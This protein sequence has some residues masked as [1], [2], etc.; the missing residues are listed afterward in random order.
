MIQ[1]DI[2]I[3][4]AGPS[5]VITSLLLAQKGIPSVLVDKC[6]FPRHKACADAIPS[7]VIRQLNEIIPGFMA[8]L[9]LEKKSLEIKGTL[10]YSPAGD[11]VKVDFLPLTG[12]TPDAAS[13]SISRIMFD[14]E[15]LLYAKSNPLIT[16]LEGH[17][18]SRIERKGKGLRVYF[19]SQ[20]SEFDIQLAIICTGSNPAVYKSIHR[21]KTDERDYAVGLR[22]YFKGALPGEF[23]NHSELFLL[24]DFMPGG[25]FLSPLEGGLFNV[26]LVIGNEIVKKKKLNLNRILADQL[27]LNPVLKNRF[28]NAALTGSVQGSR[29]FLGIKKRILSGDNFMLAGDAAGLIDLFSAN[30]IP[31]ALVSAQTAAD[32]AS[33]CL[34]AND[35]SLKKLA[36]YDEEVLRKVKKYV[37]LNMLFSP[38]FSNRFSEKAVTGLINFL[39]KHMQ[40]N[41]ALRDLMYSRKRIRLLLNP[42]FYIKLFSSGRKPDNVLS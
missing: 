13:Y 34:M 32:Y 8:R 40:H 39:F 5:G 17:E 10:L 30:G 42:L 22:A 31:Q 29:L 41:T 28:K 6:V 11:H 15:L 3:I 18:M 24:P 7:S 16:V 19:K 2:C 1:T 26:N 27:K 4:G 33:A 38:L 36:G 14:N 20:K 21:M 25:L 23:P 12:F 35:Y 9:H 37:Q